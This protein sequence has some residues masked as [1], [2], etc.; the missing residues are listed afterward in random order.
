[1]RRIFLVILVIVTMFSGVACEKN[2]KSSSMKANSYLDGGNNDVI[3]ITSVTPLSGPQSS[4]GE[5]IK[6]GAQMALDERKDSFTKKGFKL[7]FSP[8]DDK[9]DPKVGV[10]IAQK[11]IKNKNV[12]ANVAHFNSGVA[13][14]A[15]EIYK[16]DNLLMMSPANT[17]VDITRR[18]IE[19]VNRI[20]ASDDV[21]GAVAANFSFKNLKAKKVF[22]IHDKTTYGQ[23]VADEYKK[24]FE[25]LGGKIL[26]FEGITAGK[27]DYEE[28]VTKVAKA[29]PDV[30]FFGGVYPEAGLIIKQMK[31][32]NIK[33]KFV[34]PDG[35]DS[36]EL[37]KI[38]GVNVVGTYYTTTAGNSS[39]TDKGK[40]WAEK[41]KKEFNKKPESYAAY[42]YDAMQIV[43]NAMEKAIENNGGKKPTRNM[44][45]KAVKEIGVYS[46]IATKA[47]FDQKG[48]NKLAEVFIY[49]YKKAEYPATL[50]SKISAK[51]ISG[52]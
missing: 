18:G 5:A 15:S 9:A 47:E 45:T 16:T 24:A 10:S 6:N 34:G 43:L 36:D 12:L 35:V 13:M 32:K 41:Y 29:A 22:I 51:D 23:G 49:E 8:E 42:G 37:V 3:I 46:G 44:V 26:S 2:V 1:M 25:I 4:T 50:V 30:V 17:A 19:C 40:V 38:A 27:K 20:V 39:E 48:D 11:L 14:P 52:N 31:D 7:K 21:Q 33:A 28:I